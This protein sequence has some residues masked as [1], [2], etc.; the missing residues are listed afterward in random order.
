M[1]REKALE[2]SQRIFGKAILGGD[3]IV[4][5]EVKILGKPFNKIEAQEMLKA[6]SGKTHEVF[7]AYT[8]LFEAFEISR[9]VKTR[10]VLK[11]L[12]MQK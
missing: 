10:I 1:A 11:H 7:T 2:V 3:T 12:M 5:L 4:G 6:L 8:I 9:I